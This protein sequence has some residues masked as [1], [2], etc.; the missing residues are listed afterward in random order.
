MIKILIRFIFFI[1]IL[2]KAYCQDK[3]SFKV[4]LYRSINKNK[5]KVIIKESDLNYY[6]WKT[7]SLVLKSNKKISTHKFDSFKIILNGEILY[8]GKLEEWYVEALAITSPSILIGKKRI[9]IDP[10][11]SIMIWYHGATKDP[12]ENED[13][14]NFLKAN[15]LY[16]E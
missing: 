4:C 12:R 3:S 8:P 2:N 9:I 6:N 7:H 15:N 1:L 5:N 13:L 16:R 11:N 10:D 14:L